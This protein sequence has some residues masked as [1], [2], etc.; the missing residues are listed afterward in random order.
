LSGTELSIKHGDK[1]KTETAALAAARSRGLK[2]KVGDHADG[3]INIRGT[4]RCSNLA[5]ACKFQPVF[6]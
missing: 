4:L 6:L 5:S 2:K 3:I 1:K